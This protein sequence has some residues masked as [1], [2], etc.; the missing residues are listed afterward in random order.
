MTASL[1]LHFSAV[2]PIYT[3]LSRHKVG[4]SLEA[5]LFMRYLCSMCDTDA[6]LFTSFVIAS[7]FSPL[8]LAFTD[9]FWNHFLLILW[10]LCL[11]VSSGQ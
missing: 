11:G 4:T 8:M 6:F 7:L 2:R 9:I 3:F 5:A 1:H 10:K